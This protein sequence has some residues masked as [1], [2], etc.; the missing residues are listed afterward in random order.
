MKHTIYSIVNIILL[1]ENLKNNLRMNMHTESIELNELPAW[2]QT[3]TINQSLRDI[4][5]TQ[6][7][8]YLDKIH[9]INCNEK[10]L[11][12]ACINVALQK[13]YN[14]I[15]EDLNSSN[16]D[17]IE[18]I[19]TWLI[20][21]TGCQDNHYTR[22][23]SERILIATIKRVYE[24]GAKFDHMMILEGDQGIG[25][26]TLIETM[27]GKW[28]LD[29]TLE[30]KDKDLVDSIRSAIWIEFSEMSGMEKRDVD[31]LRSFLSRKV[32]CVRLSYNRFV[33]P[34][35]RRSIFIGTI[36]PSGNNMY[37][38][39]NTGNRRFWPIEC[40]V[41][42]LEY[43]R[44]YRSQLWAE[45]YVKYREGKKYWIDEHDIEAISILKGLHIE[46]EVESPTTRKIRRYLIGKNEVNM[47]EIIVS[48]LGADINRKSPKE[49]LSLQTTIGII[50][51]KE[52]WFKGT[53]ENRD[54]YYLHK[55]M[56]I[57][58]DE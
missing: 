47:D 5:L 49:L 39:D 12:D 46:R 45:A 44:Q 1:D 27:A 51:R 15:K 25:K 54:K 29:T 7:K 56:E 31:W 33:Q 16:W 57:N 22:L 41:I 50:M 13:K 8:L 37:L 35:P 23:V 53:N 20:K 3:S 6:L 21:A 42:N 32:D 14:P 36:N 2:N 17:G 38:R 9:S 40:S 18:R 30:N 19:S 10:L 26:S 4:D 34:F 24:P 48:A 28:Y 11:I 43:V 52:K 55:K 58:F